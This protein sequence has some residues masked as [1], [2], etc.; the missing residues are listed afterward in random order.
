ML[1]NVPIESLEERYSN[2]WNRW[3]P[4]EFKRLGV[5]FYT[6]YGETLT[7]K[8]ETGSFLDVYSTNYF[9][10]SQL[11]QL[12]KLLYERKIKDKDVILFHDLWFP[13]IEALQYIRQGAGIDFK[14]MGILHAGTYDPNDFLTKSGMGYWGEHLENSWFKFIDKIFVAT[15]FH[16]VLI[17]TSRHIE[18]KKIVVTGLPIYDEFSDTSI[19]KE[20]IVVFPHRLDKEKNPEEFDLFGNII[21][22]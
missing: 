2:Q 10:M 18:P 13:G 6:I 21:G 8:I 4:R 17:T 3:F 20:N 16:K 14:I 12:I 15:K 22:V 1:W 9:K 5:E 19:K 11:Q 7:D